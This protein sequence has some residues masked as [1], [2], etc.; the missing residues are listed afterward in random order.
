MVGKGATAALRASVARARSHPTLAAALVLALP[1]VVYLWP[2]LFAGRVLSPATVLYYFPPWL[3]ARP[4]HLAQHVNVLLWD[5]AQQFF[6]WQQLARQ[7]LHSGVLPQWNPYA[8][9]GTPL[10]ANAQLALFS[11]FSLPL[12]LAPGDYGL[13]LSAAIVL[14]AGGF[15]MFLLVR[16][17]Q[18]GTWPALVAGLAFALAPTN[19]VELSHPV[20]QVLAMFPWAVWLCERIVR[21]G[22]AHVGALLAI[23]VAIAM[24]GGHPGTKLHMLVVLA[25]YVVLRL[26]VGSAAPVRERVRR[27]ALVVGGTAVGGVVAAVALIPAAFLVPGSAGAAARANGGIVLPAAALR[28]LAFPDWW[29][30]P[31]GFSFVGPAN[32]NERTIFAGV[33]VLL[34]AVIGATARSRWRVTLPFVVLAALGVLVPLG[35]PPFRGVLDHLPL[36]SNVE[37]QRFLYVFSFSVPVLAAVGVGRLMETPRPPAR[38][39]IVVAAALVVG[40]VAL[41]TLHPTIEELRRVGHH[42]RT[43]VD[44]PEA[45]VIAGT[46]IVWWLLLAAAL[47]VVL[48]LRRRLSPVALALAIAAVVALDLGHFANGLQPMPPASILY[49]PTPALTALRTHVGH[50]R[51]IGTALTLV[52]D[53]SAVYGLRDVRGHDV[54]EPDSEY[55]RVF[56]LISPHEGGSFLRVPSMSA[57]GVKVAGMLAG[58]LVIQPPGTPAPPGL[59]AVYRGADADVYANPY[60]L[61]RAWVPPA[62][63]AVPTDDAAFARIADPGFDPRAAAVVQ[64]GGPAARSGRGRVWFVDDRAERVV[65]GADMRTPGLVVLGDR[66]EDGWSVAIDGRRVPWEHVDSVLRGVQVPAGRHTITWSYRTPGLV[67]GLLVT[68]AGLIALIAWFVVTRRTSAVRRPGRRASSGMRRM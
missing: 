26:A 37:N 34:L 8:L 22:R 66:A 60:A 32:F 24:L 65:L 49:P 4:P 47:G 7:Q 30:R 68:L 51:I 39:W 42:F 21:E 12:W 15:G 54:P 27:A 50:D 19:I 17:L 36:F 38:A 48:L 18:L 61:P 44:F 3:G 1:V 58:R 14:W 13:G 57:Q 25:L 16:E 28:T 6:P 23:P 56:R 52:P 33:V 43:G 5:P 53:T 29:G 20:P 31:S 63:V 40:V 62:T 46:A 10:L 64:G 59:A 11:P 55:M 35:V 67:L 9:T 45:V 41:V 2:V